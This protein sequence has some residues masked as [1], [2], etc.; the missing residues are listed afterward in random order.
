MLVDFPGCTADSGWSFV[1]DV[2]PA[3]NSV[4]PTCVWETTGMDHAVHDLPAT[5]AISATFRLGFS[6]HMKF[7]HGVRGF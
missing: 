7:L 4:S 3:E 6:S 1:V 2:V 5:V